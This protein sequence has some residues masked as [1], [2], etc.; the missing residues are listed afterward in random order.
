MIN[1][2]KKEEFC[3]LYWEI[4]IRG[5]QIIHLLSVVSVKEY[6]SFIFIFLVIYAISLS[7]NG[8][9]ANAS[10]SSNPSKFFEDGDA[11]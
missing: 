11:L 4:R 8:N 1:L 10:N 9:D 7:E 6:N 2:K 5:G 3:D